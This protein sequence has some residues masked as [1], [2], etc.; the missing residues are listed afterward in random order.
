MT[1][2]TLGWGQEKSFPL[3][4]EPLARHILQHAEKG[5]DPTPA[6][7]VHVSPPQDDPSFLAN[8]DTATH[9]RNIHTALQG[10][11]KTAVLLSQIKG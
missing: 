3:Q 4:A 6:T 2:S 5:E 8:H 9:I 11:D 10:L 1:G 7:G